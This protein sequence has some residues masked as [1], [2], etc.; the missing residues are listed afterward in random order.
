MKTLQQFLEEG[1]IKKLA[2]R[3]AKRV[4]NDAEQQRSENPDKPVV[5]NYGDSEPNSTERN[6]AIMAMMKSDSD[7]RKRMKKQKES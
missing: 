2:K 6:A 4:A 7:W 3:I 5:L 1:K